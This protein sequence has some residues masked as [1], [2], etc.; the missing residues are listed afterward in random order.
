M[1]TAASREGMKFNVQEFYNQ[2]VHRDLIL[3]S[4]VS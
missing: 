2:I 1:G 3:C 4:E